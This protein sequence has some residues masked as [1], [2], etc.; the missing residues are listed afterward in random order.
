MRVTV[1]PE[2]QT[3]LADGEALQFAFEADPNL[4][5]LQWYDTWGT[6]E[7]VRGA[8]EYFDNVTIVQPYIDAFLA[9]KARRTA[10]EEAANAARTQA[11]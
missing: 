11:G 5:A 8:A 10:I 9:E 6:Q 7:F 2:D 3:I 1:I 4:H